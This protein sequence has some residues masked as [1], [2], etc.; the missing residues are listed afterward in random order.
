MFLLDFSLVLN[1][2]DTTCWLAL[3]LTLGIAFADFV[4]LSD[5]AQVL[6]R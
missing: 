2:Q 3:N 6:L 1:K 5:Q 4:L